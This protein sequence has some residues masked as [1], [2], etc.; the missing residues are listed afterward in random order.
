MLVLSGQLFAL[1]RVEPRG[2]GDT[3]ANMPAFTQQQALY[4]KL[5]N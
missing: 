5:L 1:A 3:N 4:R 2:A